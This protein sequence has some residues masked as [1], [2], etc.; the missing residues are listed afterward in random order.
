M[1]INQNAYDFFKE[2]LSEDELSTVEQFVGNPKMVEAV[3]KVLC[4]RILYQGVAPEKLKEY[5]LRNFAFGLD[6]TG[7]M[8]DE[9]Y[10]R[11]I[12]L[13]LEALM[14][15]EQQF[16]LIKKLGE[17]KPAETKSANPAR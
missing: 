11:A 7:D 16:D 1:S 10:G 4:D 2:T 5:K 3:K 13:H 8:N 6:K 12:R 17:T 9:Q 15:V 14:L